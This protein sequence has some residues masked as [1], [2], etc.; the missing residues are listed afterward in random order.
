MRVD[1][2]RPPRRARRSGVTRRVAMCAVLCAM[3]VAMLSLGALIEVLDISAAAMASL[4]LLPILLC[5]GS[6]Y[7]WLSYAVVGILSLLLMPQS[8]GSWMFLLLTGF[9]PIL[10]RYLERLPRLLSRLIKLVLPCMVLGVYFLGFY[11]LLLGGEGGLTHAFLTCFGEEGGTPLPA[12]L[13]FFLVLLVY[14]LFDLLIERLLV[15]Y[16]L[17]WQR[18]VEK[19]MKP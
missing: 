5:Y 7:A 18:R 8:M 14:W 13:F 10:R 3:A 4:V 6:S 2:P 9:Y 16:Y 12:V 11:Y 19:W 1:S 15:L 17:K